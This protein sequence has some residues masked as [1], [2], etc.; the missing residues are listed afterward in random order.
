MTRPAE[1]EPTVL[2]IFRFGDGGGFFEVYAPWCD[3]CESDDRTRWDRLEWDGR[4]GLLSAKAFAAQALCLRCERIVYVDDGEAHR[5][6]EPVRLVLRL[7]ELR[8]EV[9]S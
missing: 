8:R 2:R 7:E 5:A 3:R 1:R 4:T 9:A 6:L